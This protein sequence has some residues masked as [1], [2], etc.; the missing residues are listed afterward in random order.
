MV[1]LRRTHEESASPFLG[2]MLFVSG[3]HSQSAETAVPRTRTRGSGF[4]RKRGRRRRNGPQL[5]VSAGM[6]LVLVEIQNTHSL[7]TRALP[8]Q[9]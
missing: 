1:L 5:V 3:A 6:S 7:S 8:H 9:T 4:G 2:S